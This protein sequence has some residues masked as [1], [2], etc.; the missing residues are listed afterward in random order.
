MNRINAIDRLQKSDRVP[1][2]SPMISSLFA[3]LNDPETMDLDLLVE[4]ISR[5]DGLEQATLSIVRSGYFGTADK[6]P[7]LRD[8]VRY[9]GTRT[10]RNLVISL[11]TR[12]LFPNRAGQA[13]KLNRE[14]CWAH[15][16]GTSVASDA[17]H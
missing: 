16:I 4:E 6:E 3:R 13:R 12:S 15:C 1:K 17:L 11:T 2:V 5:V 7:S 10:V 8:A 9:L 14:H